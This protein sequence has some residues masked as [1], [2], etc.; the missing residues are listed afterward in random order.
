[1]KTMKRGNI[2]KIRIS[3]DKKAVKS[4]GFNAE[5]RKLIALK[6]HLPLQFVG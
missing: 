3:P 4:G 1:M 5:L 2:V 6:Q